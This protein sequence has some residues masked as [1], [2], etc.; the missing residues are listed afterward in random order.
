[1]YICSDEE[2][3]MQTSMDVAKILVKTKYCLVLNETFNVE[4]NNN[5]FKIKLVEYS[6]GPKWIIIPKEKE[7]VAFDAF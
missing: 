4:V 6:Y 5:V 7:V 1:M 2:T 3:R